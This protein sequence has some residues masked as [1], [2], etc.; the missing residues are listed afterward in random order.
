MKEMSFLGDNKNNLCL[1]TWTFYI[2]SLVYDPRT[3]QSDMFMENILYDAIIKMTL[4]KQRICHIKKI[5]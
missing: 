2:Y 1:S 3:K 4:L 5:T